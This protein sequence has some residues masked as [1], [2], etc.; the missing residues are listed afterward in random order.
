[1]T[2]LIA[3][4]R[5]PLDHVVLLEALEGHLFDRGHGRPSDR[6]E[7]PLLDRGVRRELLDDA[8]D[9]LA[10]LHERTLDPHPQSA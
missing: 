6:V 2:V 10:L 9:D 1:V 8:V 4:V 7:D 3:N 5:H